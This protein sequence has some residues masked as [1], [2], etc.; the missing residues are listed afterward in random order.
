MIFV[1]DLFREAAIADPPRRGHLDWWLVGALIVVAVIE[2]I[3]NQPLFWRVWHIALVIAVIPTLLW[4]RQHPLAMLTIGFVAFNLSLLVAV[5]AR[6]EVPEGPYTAAFIL[7]NVFALFR[8]GSGRHCAIGLVIMLA[9]FVLNLIFD[10]GGI[11]ESI[12]G[13]IVLLLPQ[14]LGVVARYQARNRELAQEEVR[15]GERERIARELHDSV[16]HHV[17]AIAITAQAGRAVAANDPTQAIEA[18]NTI[19]E[20]ASRT[21]SEMRSMVGSLRGDGE[22]ELAPQPGLSELRLLAGAVGD[23]E[24]SVQAPDGVDASTAIGTALYRMAQESVTNAVRHAN[25]ASRVDVLVA[26]HDDAYHLTVSDD[27]RQNGWDGNTDGY[28]LIGMAER[29]RLL[30]GNFE[31][32]PSPTGWV[33]RAELPSEVAS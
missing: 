23:I 19:E 14:E 13:L 32:G 4:R 12:G 31:A 29:A 33:V 17:S 24:V 7:I 27:G 21:L 18:L 26:H 20:A 2:G 8:W 28:G 11:G 16:A 22:A 10:Y 3:F 30:G 6:G 9:A 5:I 15:S 1:R 25:G